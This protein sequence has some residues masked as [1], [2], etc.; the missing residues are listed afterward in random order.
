MSSWGAT[1][2]GNFVPTR[3]TKPHS[4]I[5][6][7]SVNFPDPSV[8]CIIGASRG[9]GAGIAYAYAKAGATGL[10][11]SSRRLSGL[12]ETATRC[13]EIN[14]D[15][16][17]EIILCDISSN[18]DVAALAVKIKSTFG[19][20]DI[21]VVNSGYSGPV[22]LKV[23]EDDPDTVRKVTDINYLGTY[24][25]AHHLVPLLLQSPPTSNCTKAFL[26][27]GSTAAAVVRGPI[28]NTQ[29]CI[30]KLAQLKL[31]EHIHEQYKDQGLL[32]VAVHPGAVKTE[33]AMD[34]APE[35]FMQYLVDDPALCGAFMVWLTK[36][37]QEKRLDWLGG[38][39]LEAKW[40]VDELEGRKE[41]IVK[42]ELLKTKIVV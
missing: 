33:M 31:I 4:A 2:V 24:Y 12:Q 25:A 22:V 38:R 9:I 10:V 7:S 26:A 18:D 34:S 3:Y 6:P 15:L 40:D 1:G 39:H 16:K 27:V 35:A 28:A 8:V 5:D 36:P 14:P 41:D 29:Y 37:R 21:A 19:R 32:A 42:S 17:I 13:K 20:L 30:S 11:L 23:G